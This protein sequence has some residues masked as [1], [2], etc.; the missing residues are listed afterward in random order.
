[1]PWQNGDDESPT[2]SWPT[3]NSRLNWARNNYQKKPEYG[4]LWLTHKFLVMLA[5]LTALSALIEEKANERLLTPK[6]VKEWKGLYEQWRPTQPV[7]RPKNGSGIGP[8]A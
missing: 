6:Q 7:G 5:N 1:M 4:A 2:G 8:T 3:W